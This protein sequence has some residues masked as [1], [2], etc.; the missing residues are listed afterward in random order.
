VRD[1]LEELAVAERVARR[2]AEQLHVE[3]EPEEAPAVAGA[4]RAVLLVPQRERGMDQTVL[5]ARAATAS[6]SS[7]GSTLNRSTS[8]PM[9]RAREAV[10]AVNSS[11]ENTLSRLSIA[12]VCGISPSAAPPAAFPVGESGST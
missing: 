8:C 1:E 12:T 2:L 6:P 10:Q 11:G 7:F 5:P 3:T 9:R 4:G